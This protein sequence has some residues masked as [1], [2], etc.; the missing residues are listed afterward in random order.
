VLGLLVILVGASGA[1]NELQ[2]ALNIVW[3]VNKSRIWQPVHLGGVSLPFRS[4]ITG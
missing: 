2:D 4:A 3:K 1:F